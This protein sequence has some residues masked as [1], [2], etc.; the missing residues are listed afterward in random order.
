MIWSGISRRN[1]L[2]GL[3][4]GAGA[5]VLSPLTERLL[6]EARGEAG[7]IKRLVVVLNGNGM[8]YDNFIP[9][10]Y[11][12]N[13][14]KAKRLNDSSLISATDFELPPMYSNLAPLR[15]RLLL[16]DGL[17]NRNGA[18]HTGFY[19]GLSC[20]PNI[21]TGEDGPPGGITLKP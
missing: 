17:P 2:K 8:H 18:G 9:L 11:R 21:G 5:T 3:S 19:V 10:G 14:L 13:D 1:L 16:V 4:F 7:K 20:V 15:D 6:S 12:G